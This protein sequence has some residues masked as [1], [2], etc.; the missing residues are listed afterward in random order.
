[1]AGIATSY[2]WERRAIIRRDWPAGRDVHEI[3]A[4]I[5]T[6]P[7]RKVSSR[8]VSVMAAC[9][10]LKRP[11]GYVLQLLAAL[12]GLPRKKYAP[13][14]GTPKEP[15]P[16]RSASSGFYWSDPTTIAKMRALWDEGLPASEIGERMGVSKNAVVGKAHRLGF[17]ARPS[18]IRRD[19]VRNPRNVNPRPPP[20]PKLP[21]ACDDASWTPPSRVSEPPTVVSSAVFGPRA[22][23]A[24]CW[25]LSEWGAKAARFCEGASLAGKPYCQEH[26]ERAYVRVRKAA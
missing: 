5:N 12:R 19:G 18:P 4:E 9:L 16:K 7:G 14:A 3:T 24:C 20:L 11:P 17:P 21:S 1:M 8:N 15:A 6:L 22:S 23:R 13:R 2:S 25:P 26:A 10:R